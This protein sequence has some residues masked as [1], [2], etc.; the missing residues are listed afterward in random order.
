MFLGYSKQQNDNNKNTKE[1]KDSFYV[2]QDSYRINCDEYNLQDLE[3]LKTTIIRK[4]KKIKHF[5]KKIKK[6]GF[7]H[8]NIAV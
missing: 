1:C 4:G 3:Q 2:A 5:I 8:F 7:I 6:I